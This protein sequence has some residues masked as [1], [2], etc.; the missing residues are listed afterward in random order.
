LKKIRA[1]D[2]SYC[3]D[4]GFLDT[5]AQTIK[6][7]DDNVRQRITKLL[8]LGTFAIFSSILAFYFTFRM[9]KLLPT[10]IFYHFAPDKLEIK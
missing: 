6:N 2:K 5:L 4:C 7:E 8:G 1:K 10:N 9:G 3:S